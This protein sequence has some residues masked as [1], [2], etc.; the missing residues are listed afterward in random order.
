MTSPFN[1]SMRERRGFLRLRPGVAAQ[2]LILLA[3][4]VLAACGGQDAGREGMNPNEVLNP[5]PPAD[6]GTNSLAYGEYIIV[7]YFEPR[8]VI[9]DGT[10]RRLVGEPIEV[11][12]G[13]HIITLDGPEDFEPLEHY[14]SVVGTT[15]VMP[16]EIEF[17]PI[18][19]PVADEEE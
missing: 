8:T 6:G 9:V 4:V 5:D 14:V 11:E 3:L 7:S 16:Q 1:T 2:A 12:P 15:A 18:A 17:T 10:R 19:P 13:E